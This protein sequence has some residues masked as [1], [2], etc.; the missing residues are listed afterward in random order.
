MPF[1]SK[2]QQGYLFA[3]NP[4]VAK[5]FA[6]KTPKA[7]YKKLPVHVKKAKSAY[8]KMRAK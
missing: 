5:E 6:A 1:K 4:K 3:N 7:A 8:S 2:A